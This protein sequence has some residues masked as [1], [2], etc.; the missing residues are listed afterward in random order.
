MIDFLGIGAQKAGTTWLYAQLDRH[1]QV[2]FPA[3]KEVHF[4]DRRR[5]EGAAAWLA[6]FPRA[7]PGVR[8]GEITPA[9]ALLE[10]ETI[11]EIRRHCPDLRI[12]Y[13]LRNPAERA[14]SAAL[15]A[16]ERAELAFDE[17]SDAWFADHFRSRGSRQRG[18]YLGALE[19]WGAAFPPEQIH[20]IL[21]DDIL[22]HPRRVLVALARHLGIETAPYESVPEAALREPVFPGPRLPLRPTLRPVLRELY[23]EPIE[24]LARRL[25]R[26]LSPWRAWLG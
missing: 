19:R 2:R 5:D 25:G 9:Y 17:A 14:W 18:D 24:A 21:F 7:E 3:G 11:A 20:V 15:M 10:R 8:Q 23:A 22:E 13:S 6:L 4:W 26:D 1:P 12:F 16:L